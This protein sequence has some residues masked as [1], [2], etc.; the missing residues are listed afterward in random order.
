MTVRK[1]GVDGEFDGPIIRQKTDEPFS[2][3]I[4]S[5]KKAR[6][7]K[8]A[9][10]LKSKGT[11]QFAVVA[12]GVTIDPHLNGP[13]VGAFKSPLIPMRIIRVLDAVV[14]RQIARLL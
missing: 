9:A 11:Q 3:H 13:P 5:D 12:H 10:S 2:F 6:S 8:H 14:L 4:L 1:D 7:E